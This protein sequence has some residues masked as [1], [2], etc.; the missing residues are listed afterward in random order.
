MSEKPGPCPF[1]K[2]EDVTI[3][4]EYDEDWVLGW[5]NCE[6]CGATGPSCETKDAA[7]AAW[8]APGERVAALVNL[9]HRAA[10][11][12]NSLGNLTNWP[13]E[14]PMS[15]AEMINELRAATD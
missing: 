15:Y 9:C 6:S 1:C 14:M 4:Y 11:E 7:I 3:D 12:M 10:A 5:G 13:P 2:S 8:N